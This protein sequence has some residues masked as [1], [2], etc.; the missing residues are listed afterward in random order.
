M[1]REVLVGAGGKCWDMHIAYSDN[2]RKKPIP[3]AV[4]ARAAGT[5]NKNKNY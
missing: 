3:V 4:M 5:G 1:L 2:K